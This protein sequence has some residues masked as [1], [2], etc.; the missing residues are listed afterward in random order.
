MM[1]SSC[2]PWR[3]AQARHSSGGDDTASQLPDARASPR[4]DPY[5]LLLDAHAVEALQQVVSLALPA[6][7]QAEYTLDCSTEARLADRL[8]TGIRTLRSSLTSLAQQLP[9]SPKE[10][11]QMRI[12]LA[13]QDVG[14]PLTS[15]EVASLARVADAVLNDVCIVLADISRDEIEEVAV[16]SLTASRLAVSAAQ[17]AVR[18]L[19]DVVGKKDHGRVIIEDISE[20]VGVQEVSPASSTPPMQQQVRLRMCR[21]HRRLLWPPLF[22]LLRCKLYDIVTY[23]DFASLSIR[24]C[25]RG[26]SNFCS[27]YTILITATAI[28][29]PLWI[30][31]FCVVAIL[32]TCSMPWVLMADAVLQRLY[33]PRARRIDAV[34]DGC[35]KFVR[36]W[37]VAGR[38]VVRRVR[39]MIRAMVQRSLG[40]RTC[41]QALG[42]S[43]R[44]FCEDPFVFSQAALISFYAA[45]KHAF[46]AARAAWAKLPP[47]VEVAES[48]RALW[49]Q[50]T[51][52]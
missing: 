35:W 2:M 23:S 3:S 42:D 9:R 49:S 30:I 32:A 28:L 5:A 6:L 44:E 24:G 41:L 34:A 39:R 48:V 31:P 21:P 20:D 36:L 14:M 26:L 27:Q 33:E 52:A 25:W 40:G 38:L 10:I 16:V 29:S 7:E 15:D 13:E 47:A 17:A 11:E 1:A 46:G 8:E 43:F 45:A 4:G 37:F 18:R 19:Q 50:P 22:P 51:H 12:R